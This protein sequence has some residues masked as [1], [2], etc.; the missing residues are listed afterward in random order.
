[1][2]T[3]IVSMTICLV[4]ILALPQANAEDL[5]YQSLNDNGSTT[6]GVKTSEF[7]DAL[8]NPQQKIETI[9]NIAEP[10]I[11]GCGPAGCGGD[12]CGLGDGCG[13]GCGGSSDCGCLFGDESLLMLPKNADSC[14][15][16]GWKYSLG[17]ELRHR[18]M[19][20]NNRLRPAG[21]VS[22][23]TY[24]LWRF[25]PFAELKNE[26]VTFYVQGIDAAIFG[27]DIGKLPIDENRADLLQYYVDVKAADLE[28]GVLRYRYGRQF[29]KY[30]GQRLL[31]PLGWANTFRNFEGHKLYYA[32]S[33]WNIDA[34][35]MRAVNGAAGNT[36]RPKSFDTPDQSGTVNGVYSTYKGL[37]KGT[38]DLYWL[39]TDEDEERVNRMDGRRHTVGAR[40]AGKHAVKECKNV[41]RTFDWDLEGAYQFGSDNFTQGGNPAINQDVSAG[42]L[43]GSGGVTFNDKPWTPGIKGVFWWGSGDND[44]T[45]GE[46][47]TVSTLYPL[48]HAYWGLI[49]NFNGSNLLDA[50]VQATVKPTKKLTCLA[51]WHWFQKD[52]ANDF[53]YNIAGAPLGSNANG[54]NDIGQELDLVATYAVN[55]NFNVQLGYFMFWY[56][57][58]VSSSALA[59]PD[60]DQ[61]YIQTSWKF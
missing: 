45:D 9:V 55:K 26:W 56:A 27:E 7:S 42:F 5:S 21:N 28:N 61:F 48:G 4:T 18:Y 52:E 51:A 36:F 16:E 10:P 3:I 37:N 25:T 35:S 11:M 1:M 23:S 32:G 31:S 50:S 30:G 6:K 12:S 43:F 2:R 22:R 17:G 60:A 19:S 54:L 39:Y 8:N 59:R 53:I 20:E 46:I 24:D 40:W 14:I 49:D 58:A 44:P 15:F 33:D 38:L 13:L 47:N 57:D 29:L 41:V 34:F